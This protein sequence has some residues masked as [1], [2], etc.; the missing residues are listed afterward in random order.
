MIVIVCQLGLKQDH[1]LLQANKADVNR[2]LEDLEL[3]V[4]GGG[5]RRR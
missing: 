1:M 5:A 4:Q 2:E 3:E